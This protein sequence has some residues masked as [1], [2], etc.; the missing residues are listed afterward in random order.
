MTEAA[1]HAELF[2]KIPEFEI[3]PADFQRIS[4]PFP[5]MLGGNYLT[6]DETA[7]I[8]SS[9]GYQ[10]WIVYHPEIP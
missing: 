10:R 3:S 4:L 8:E 2:S 7:K 9:D 6:E 1:S 5:L